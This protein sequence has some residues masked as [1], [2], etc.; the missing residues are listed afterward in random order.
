MMTTRQ[1]HRITN[2]PKLPR[3]QCKHTPSQEEIAVRC[4][5]IRAEWTEAERRRR[6]R[7]GAK[8]FDIENGART[9]RISDE[10]GEVA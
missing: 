3:D 1:I 5:E 4:A 10:L 6:G 9:A 8:A 2:A 7:G